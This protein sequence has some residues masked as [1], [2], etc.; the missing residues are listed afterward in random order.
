MRLYLSD[1]YSVFASIGIIVLLILIFRYHNS[2]DVNKL[3]EVNTTNNIS[4]EVPECKRFL[5][6]ETLLVNGSVY[7][8]LEKDVLDYKCQQ[9]SYAKLNYWLCKTDCYNRFVEV[10]KDSKDH[11][12]CTFI[13][14]HTDLIVSDDNHFVLNETTTISDVSCG[15]S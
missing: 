11:W 8:L 7:G 13:G 9:R 12:C 5:P 14:N 3:I 2:E 10:E 15:W 4:L 6:N 1:I